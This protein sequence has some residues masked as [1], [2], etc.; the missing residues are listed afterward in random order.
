MAGHPGRGPHGVA[1]GM[2]LCVLAAPAAAQDDAAAGAIDVSALP[3]DLERV[4]RGLQRSSEEFSSEDGR[5]NLEVVVN[6]FGQAPPLNFLP[7][8]PNVFTGPPP[9][10]I[11]VSALPID[12]ER[13]QRGLQRS[14][15]EFSAEDGRLNLAV[16]VNVFGQAPPR[17]FLPTG[18]NVFTGPPPDGPPT[19][20]EMMRI[21]TPREF[22]TP[23]MDFGAAIQWLRDSLRSRGPQERR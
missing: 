22:Q 16:V 5:L 12:L 14:S 15:E 19:H 1:L 10:G 13:I 8:G 3:I 2:L 21:R 6:V 7:T 18:P 11:D 4:Q 9:G 23:V 20:A 17:N